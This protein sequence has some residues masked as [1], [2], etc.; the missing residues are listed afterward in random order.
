MF[1]IK[2]VFL[3]IR[4]PLK[5]I[6]MKATIALALISTSL[7][8]ED[9]SL[10]HVTSPKGTQLQPPSLSLPNWTENLPREQSS[11]QNEGW[12]TPTLP[13]WTAVVLLSGRMWKVRPVAKLHLQFLFF[14]KTK[15]GVKLDS[16]LSDSM[17]IDQVC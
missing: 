2:D 8:T 12:C 7:Q 16:I 3:N 17:E 6:L 14:L 11:L 13:G 4:Y 10:G 15:S 9:S 1:L 5:T